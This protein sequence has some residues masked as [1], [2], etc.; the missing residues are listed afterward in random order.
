MICAKR[1]ETREALPKLSSVVDEHPESAFAPT[2]LLLSGVLRLQN[3]EYA[4]AQECF[5]RIVDFFPDNAEV[6]R[7]KDYF[8]NLEGVRSSVPES[9]E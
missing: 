1:Q 9:G 8:T 7:A 6:E 2:A 3:Q 5:Q 4:E